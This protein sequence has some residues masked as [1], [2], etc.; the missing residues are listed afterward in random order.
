M[1]VMRTPFWTC[2]LNETLPLC[3]RFSIVATIGR[4]RSPCRLEHPAHMKVSMTLAPRWRYYRSRVCTST[5]TPCRFILLLS[6]ALSVLLQ[7]DYRLSTSSAVSDYMSTRA[8][9]RVSPFHFMV[10]MRQSIVGDPMVS[11]G[12][13]F[14]HSRRNHQDRVWRSLRSVGRIVRSLACN[15]HPGPWR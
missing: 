5:T 9:S 8:T 2:C 10:C 12:N 4:S 7:Y 11:A 3:S 13:P 15:I 6:H 14:R 1:K